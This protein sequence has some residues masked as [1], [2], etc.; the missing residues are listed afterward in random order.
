MKRAAVVARHNGLVSPLG[1][2]NSGASS[3][4]SPPQPRATSISASADGVA[5]G[6]VDGLLDFSKGPTVKSELVCKWVDRTSSR[7]RLGRTATSVC[8]QTFNSMHEL[9][10]H[11]TTEHVAVGLETLSHVCM[12]DECLRGGKA[13]KAKYKLI[14]HIRVHTG[15]KPFSCAFP[16]CGKMFAR[17]ENLKIH[18]RTHTGEKPFQCEFCERRFANSSDRK[19]H[20][21]VHTASKP[22]DCKA[23]GCTKSYTH[24]SSLRKHMK[25]H[26]KSSPTSEPKD[27]YDSIPYQLQQ[28]HQALLEPL[29]LKM[30]RLSPSPNR[31]TNFPLLSNREL[32]IS[33][34]SDVDHK[35]LL[36][37]SSPVAMPLD[38]SL[39]GLK[40]Q[41]AQKQQSGRTPRRSQR[42]VNPALPHLSNIKEWYVCT[43]T[44]AP[45]V[46][47]I[48]PDHIKSEP[49]DDEEYVT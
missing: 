44:T 11:V 2:N 6:G 17:S 8:D 16:N 19:K 40:T 14:N 4:V 32:D 27:L 15:E 25:V 37:S 34:T 42:S 5:G 35:L 46:H 24:P 23:L 12:W 10:D 7:Q 9:V 45:Q 3:I 20:S 43:R 36:R 1:N 31:N 41:L 48:H 26:V 21:Q 33:T 47:L 28:P 18:T 39:S 49:S 13:F 22:Y 29:D 38:L 30:N